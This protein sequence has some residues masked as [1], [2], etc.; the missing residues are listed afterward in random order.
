VA[1]D[2]VAQLDLFCAMEAAPARKTA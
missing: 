1:D 2:T